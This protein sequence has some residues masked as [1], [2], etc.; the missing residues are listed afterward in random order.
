MSAI[1]PVVDSSFE[2]FFELVCALADYEKLDRPNSQA[3]QRLAMDITGPKPRIEAYLLRQE[4]GGA[5]GY[6]IVLET[7][8]SF[9]ALPTLYLE[10]IF[11][12]EEHRGKGLGS[13]LFDF[14]VDLARSRG[15]GRI[16]WQVLDWNT[17]ARE[18]YERKGAECMDQWLLCR[19]TL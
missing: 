5:A 6:A 15:C 18:F 16:D 1:E 3:K 17:P 11:V 9:L 12:L 14:I 2:D 13:T 4:D 8:S 10:D 19:I 7:Y